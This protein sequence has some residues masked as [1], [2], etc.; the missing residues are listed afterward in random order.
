MPAQ[1]TGH[2]LEPVACAA[3]T[4]LRVPATVY[5]A[6]LNRNEPALP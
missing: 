1:T 4:R 6:V 2:Y 5:N 3:N